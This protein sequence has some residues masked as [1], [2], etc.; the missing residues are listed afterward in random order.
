MQ[1]RERSTYSP[2]TIQRTLRRKNTSVEEMEADRVQGPRELK[3]G[4]SKV[5]GKPSTMS[6][7]RRKNRVNPSSALGVGRRTRRA[8][9]HKWYHQQTV[10]ISLQRQLSGCSLDRGL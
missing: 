2:E 9:K 3:F 7:R 10:D 4:I 6:L 8:Q 5:I 1:Q